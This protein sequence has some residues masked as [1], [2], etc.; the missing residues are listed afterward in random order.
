MSLP[1]NYGMPGEE[2]HRTFRNT[3]IEFKKLIKSTKNPKQLEEQLQKFIEESKAMNWHPKNTG[4]YHKQEGE[5]LVDKVYAE[6]KRYRDD[7]EPLLNKADPTDLL[8]ALDLMEQ[9]IK[10]FKVT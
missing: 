8:N 3:C 10:S 4:V 1:A 6:F 9:Y 7:L 2:L 5:K